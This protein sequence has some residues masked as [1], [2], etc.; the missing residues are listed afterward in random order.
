M[1]QIR[2]FFRNY[3]KGPS[4]LGLEVVKIPAQSIPRL[5]SGVV[6]WVLF[7]SGMKLSWFWVSLDKSGI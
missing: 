5:Y 4:W 7:S 2:K 3:L 6:G 1:N